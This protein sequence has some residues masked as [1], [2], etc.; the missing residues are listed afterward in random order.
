MKNLAVL[1]YESNCLQDENFKDSD[2]R[3]WLRNYNFSS[4]SNSSNRVDRPIFLWD[5]H[6]HH[7][8][9]VFETV[10]KSS[11]FTGK[12]QMKS[13]SSILTKLWRLS[14]EAPLE[15]LVSAI[16]EVN[17]SLSMR[18][19][20]TQEHINDNCASSQNLQKQRLTWFSF[21]NFGKITVA[22]CLFF[23]FLAVQISILLW[24][25]LTC[26]L[27]FTTNETQNPW[28]SKRLSNAS[29]SLLVKFV[30]GSNKLS[31]WSN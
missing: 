17:E 1:D 24:S 18:N 25:S 7:H 16:A 8:V 15:R 31:R 4:V 27:F 21:R 20:C 23:C 29:P 6:P 10:F 13:C 28:L 11:N 30:F 12:L 3:N 22:C 9:A 2:T 14:S 5:A 26:C 19:V